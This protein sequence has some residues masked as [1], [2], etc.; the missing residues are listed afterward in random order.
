[1]NPMKVR[2]LR[3]CGPAHAYSLGLVH[4]ARR[5]VQGSCQLLLQV[6]TFLQIWGKH[7]WPHFS[8]GSKDS[9]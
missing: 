6:S 8:D 2:D 4:S 9:H 3:D 5:L 7:L 1:M